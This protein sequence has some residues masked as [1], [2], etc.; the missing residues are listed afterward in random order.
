MIFNSAAPTSKD[1][2]IIFDSE[3]Y[4]LIYFNTYI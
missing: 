2:L 4:K 1:C 3:V